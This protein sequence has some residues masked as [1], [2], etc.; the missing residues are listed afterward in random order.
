MG[1]LVFRIGVSLMA[2]TGI[3]IIIFAIKKPL[4]LPGVAATANPNKHENGSRDGTQTQSS[5]VNGTELLSVET[6]L[7]NTSVPLSSETVLLPDMA[8]RPRDAN[9]T[10]LL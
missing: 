10:E 6:E 5:V 3:I 9:V 7:L 2:I 8:E 1:E 4:Y